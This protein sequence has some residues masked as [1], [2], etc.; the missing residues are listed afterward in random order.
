MK[1]LTIS[2]VKAKFDTWNSGESFITFET[3]NGTPVYD[4][5]TKDFRGFATEDDVTDIVNA[6][7]AHAYWTDR[8]EYLPSEDESER[9]RHANDVLAF[10]G[11]ELADYHADG[12]YYD[13]RYI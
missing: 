5:A 4:V 1:K 2:A 13:L 10:C 12:G 9:E 11:V 7:P 6:D 8:I 3:T